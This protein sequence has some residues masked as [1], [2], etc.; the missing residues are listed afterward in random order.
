MLVMQLTIIID[1]MILDLMI[2]MILIPFA[3][4][5]THLILNDAILTCSLVCAMSTN[6]QAEKY[7]DQGNEE[8]RN[9]RVYHIYNHPFT[10][11]MLFD[12]VPL[13]R[14]Q[15]YNHIVSSWILLT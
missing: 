2:P 13:I 5:F 14:I 12:L 6:K 9:V 7:K 10:S 3:S 8:F 11:F 15:I 4:Y 1:L